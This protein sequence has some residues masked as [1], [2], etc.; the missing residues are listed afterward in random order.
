MANGNGGGSFETC[1][2]VGA[3]ADFGR[4]PFRAAFMSLFGSYFGDWDVTNNFMRAP[5]AGN[6]TG[7]GLGLTCFWA[8][9]PSFFMHHMAT[10]ETVGYAM[11]TSMNSQFSTFSNPVYQP[12]NFGGGGTHCGLLGDPSLHMHV[13]EPPRHLVA[14]SANS[15]V[16]LAWAA[17]TEPNLLGYH[18][19]RADSPDGPFTRL[20]TTSAASNSYEDTN[21]TAGNAYTYM[22]R[23]LKLEN[24]PGGTYENLSLGEIATITVHAGASGIPLNPTGLA[25]VQQSSASA[26]LTW[27][28]NATDETG[29]RVER[30]NG[31]AGAFSGVANLGAGATSH[32][33]SGA[34]AN[35]EVYYYRVVAVNAAGDSLPSNEASFDACPVFFEFGTTLTKTSK[36]I[37]TAEIPVTRFG[38]VNGG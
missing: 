26:L 7:D 33:D 25:V 20:T 22:V 18:V 36:T 8:G 16:S 3:T 2:S 5:L 11:R 27:Q 35:N 9:R 31:A 30:K 19:Y 1:S 13:V 34:F 24:A 12:V 38:G 32:T 29:Y 10:G 14:T 15:G 6:A 23:V 21:G 28:D 17:S 37:G 4:R